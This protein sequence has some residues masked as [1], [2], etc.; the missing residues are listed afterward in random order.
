MSTVRSLPY[1]GVSLMETPPQTEPSLN[2]DPRGS[3]PDRKWHHTES[4]PPLWTEWHTGVKTLPC[5]KLR[6]WAVEMW[7]LTA[8]DLALQWLCFTLLS[9]QFD[10]NSN[11][12]NGYML[13][14]HIWD[15]DFRLYDVSHMIK[16]NL[17]LC[18]HICAM[19]Q[20]PR[21]HRYSRLILKWTMPP[22]IGLLS[23]DMFSVYLWCYT[24]STFW[25]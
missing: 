14:R 5:P 6:L 10:H 1:R 17:V 4:P 23:H 25:F 19:G 22:L 8:V 7:P 24:S 2:R 11:S 3:Q 13:V 12:K 9:A 18:R 21:W 16:L 15:E 20:V